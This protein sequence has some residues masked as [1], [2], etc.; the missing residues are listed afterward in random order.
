LTEDYT[1]ISIDVPRWVKARLQLQGGRDGL[2]VSPYSCQLLI[3]S[4]LH[5][6]LEEIHRTHGGLLTLQRLTR[7][8]SHDDT[9]GIIQA[10][11]KDSTRRGHQTEAVS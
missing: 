5:R 11:R 9:E 6:D 4:V 7:P 8:L 10:L 1:K 3:K 2:K